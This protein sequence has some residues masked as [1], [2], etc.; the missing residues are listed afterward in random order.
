ML[1]PSGVMLHAFDLYLAEAISTER[2]F[3]SARNDDLVVSDL[4][5]SASPL[6]KNPPEIVY[7]CV[8][9]TCLHR[10][11]TM[12]FPPHS[13]DHSSDRRKSEQYITFVLCMVVRP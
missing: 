11:L 13:E 8:S 2:A 5:L 12:R 9:P 1:S 10:K 4:S 6:I 7:V 3:F